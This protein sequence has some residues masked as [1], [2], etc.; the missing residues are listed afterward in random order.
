MHGFILEMAF[1]NGP[2]RDERVYET[3]EEHM[4]L[5]IDVHVLPRYRSRLHSAYKTLTR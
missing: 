3:M 5:I 4:K 1:E 2:Q